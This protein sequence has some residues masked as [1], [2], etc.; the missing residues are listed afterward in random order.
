MSKAF[1]VWFGP[2]LR[3]DWVSKRLSFWAATSCERCSWLVI[4]TTTLNEYDSSAMFWTSMSTITCQLSI[5][6]S[7]ATTSQ[8]NAMLS[9][10]FLLSLPNNC[11]FLS[12]IDFG[13]SSFWRAG[14]RFWS[15]HLLFYAPFSLRFWHVGRGS[16]Q[17]L[18]AICKG[19]WLRVGKWWCGNCFV[20]WRWLITWLAI[21]LGTCS[22]WKEIGKFRLCN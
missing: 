4:M 11:L 6:I 2:C 14:K 13:H 3:V 19:C 16:C 22:N 9:A 10:G 5:Y 1:T 7:S 8:H 21:Y 12:S 15:S 17:G 20:Q 18:C